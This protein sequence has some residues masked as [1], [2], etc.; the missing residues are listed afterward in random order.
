MY[1]YM[2]VYTYEYYICTHAHI[3]THVHAA[4][5][6][7]CARLY[8]LYICMYI[9]ISHAFSLSLYISYIHVNIWFHV[10]RHRLYL[11]CSVSDCGSL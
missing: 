7:I 5:V 8:T 2:Y 6:N 9:F 1:R 11:K 10:D 4:H 3:Y